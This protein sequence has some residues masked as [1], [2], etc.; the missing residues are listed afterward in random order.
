MTMSSTVHRRLQAILAAE[1]AD[2]EALGD[3]Y[4]KSMVGQNCHLAV[5]DRA[6][7][8]MRPTPLFAELEQ[9]MAEVGPALVILDTLSD[10]FGG[11]ENVRAHAR[12]FIGLLNGLAERFCCAIVVLGHPSVAG[13]E[14]GSGLSG[15]TAWN[16]SVRSRLY[17]ERI[18]S[19]DG[20]ETDP[21]KRRLTVKK[22]NYAQAGL[23]IVMTWREGVFEADAPETEAERT[24]ASDKAK[25]VFLKL[26]RAF[27]EEGRDVHSASGRGF[28][29]AGFAEDPRSERVT[30]RAF[31]EAMAALFAEGRL[32]VEE[33]GSPSRRR[34]RIVEVPKS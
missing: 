27:A 6:A 33:F 21:D 3:L 25:R 34:R 23:E 15:S 18:L 12:Q 13:M 5:L 8:I 10:L 16:G 32:R 11:D 4:I 30:K 2:M 7:G 29:P 31:R 19:R 22:A 24:E 20:K 26:L 9:Q 14:R 17:L 28:A 1:G